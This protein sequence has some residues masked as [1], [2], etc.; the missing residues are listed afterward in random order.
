M[1]NFRSDF[2]INKQ[3]NVK[4]IANFVSILASPHTGEPLK[5]RGDKLIS[6]SGRSY[7]LV[8]GV[9]VLV[10]KAE[11]MHVTPPE[12]GKISKTHAEY[13]VPE[14]HKRA[15]RV[16]HLGSGNVPTSDSRVISLGILPCSQVDVVGE[17]EH[18]PFL[19]N[20]FDFVDS[21]AVFEHVYDPIAAINEVKR[22]LKPKGVFRINNSFYQPYHGFPGHYFAL[23]PQANETYL[24][25]DFKILESY[26]PESGTAL[27]S[28]NMTINR[29]M[30]NLSEAQKQK[31]LSMPVGK[32]LSHIEKDT[33][34]KNSFMNNYSMYEARAM[35]ATHVV[36]A[37]KPSNYEKLKSRITG[38][39]EKH[40]T[41][42]RLKRQYYT[43]RTELILR[44][45]EIFLYKRMTLELNK[46]IDF[47]HLAKIEP[48]EVILKEFIVENPLKIKSLEVTIEAMQQKESELRSV[49]N[50][51][52]NTWLAEKGK[53]N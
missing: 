23:T 44:H 6:S 30:A 4:K 40:D 45:H 53:K 32:F 36:I 34:S 51:I 39:S 14:Q 26:I 35:A 7:R 29:F 24:V 48:I 9:P 43:L 27:M 22:V 12:E 50:P 17:A 46:K 38:D 25:D 28:V 19:D 18:L 2:K 31:F 47:S 3:S 5:L 11:P 13:V 15:K 41:W 16:L 21:T 8:G 20:S 52:I 10:L 37:Q 42:Q 1:L 49:R 33:T